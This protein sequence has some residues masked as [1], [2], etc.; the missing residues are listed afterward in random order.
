MSEQSTPSPAPKD[1]TPAGRDAWLESRSLH[2]FFAIIIGAALFGFFAGTRSH[3]YEHIALSGY[4]SA[5]R[6][7]P[8]A[9]AS[10]SYQDLM[11]TPFGSRESSLAD[12]DRARRP[13][14]DLFAQVERSP[15]A[16]QAARDDRAKNRAYEG[17]PPTIPHAV[18][19]TGATEC[20]ACH[21]Q[22]MTIDGKTASPMSHE[23]LT[24][25]TQCHVEQ[26]GTLPVVELRPEDILLDNS[27]VGL[28]SFGQIDPAYDGAPPPIPHPTRMRTEC[29]SCH[30]QI[31]R[32]GL[33]TT[34]PW[35][36]QCVQC[37]APSAELDLRPQT[38]L[39]PFW[40]QPR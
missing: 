9:P 8:G 34:H 30:G 21:A 40:D 4:T 38:A 6:A 31:A 13:D 28:R 32:P 11:N 14:Q 29:A 5:E 1:P 20:M 15:Q 26:G 17:A 3:T 39:L 35:R 27:F 16:L 18:R 2:I 36:S 19:Q 33:K 24:N 7:E 37:H 10:P 12:L 25:C 23:F 22:G